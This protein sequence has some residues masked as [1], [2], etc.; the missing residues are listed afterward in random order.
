M[1]KIKYQYTD[2][3]QTNNT[4][5]LGRASKGLL[6]FGSAARIRSA[7]SGSSATSSLGAAFLGSGFLAAFSFLAC[8][9]L[10]PDPLSSA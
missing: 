7:A 2:T 5:P 4:Y 6:D 9:F 3:A 10:S 1:K 8:G